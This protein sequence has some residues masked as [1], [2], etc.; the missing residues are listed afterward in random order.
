M[1][2]IRN[3]ETSDNKTPDYVTIMGRITK[4]LTISGTNM[5]IELHRSLNGTV[6][7][8]RS[9]IKKTLNVHTFLEIDRSPQVWWRPQFQE[10]NKG[11]RSSIRNVSFRRAFTTAIYCAS[12][13]IIIVSYHQ[14]KESLPMRLCVHK[15]SRIMSTNRKNQ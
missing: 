13:P 2:K 11:P 15:K 4:K 9:M 6:I 8:K 14:H 10:N 7:R 12:S 1:H 3:I 5:N